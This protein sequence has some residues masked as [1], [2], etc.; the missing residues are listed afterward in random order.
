MQKDPQRRL[1]NQR[2]KFGLIFLLL[3]IACK[4]KPTYNG[5]I[6]NIDV[7]GSFKENVNVKVVIDNDIVLNKSIKEHYAV[8][9]RVTYDANDKKK[10]KMFFSRWT[11]Y[12]FCP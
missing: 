12:V 8:D 3:F 10:V 11:R 2:N 7:F 4:K 6:I 5:P 9:R 1:I